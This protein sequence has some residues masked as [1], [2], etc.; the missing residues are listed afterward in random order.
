MPLIMREVDIL[1]K[2]DNSHIVKFIESF[3]IQNCLYFILEYVE[4][5]SLHKILNKFGAL[6]ENLVGI[7]TRQALE[8]L[9]YLHSTNV[10]HRDIK[11]DNML[12]TKDG[13][14]KL[15]DF[16]SVSVTTNEGKTNMTNSVGGTPYWMAPE[17]IQMEGTFPES[18]IW[19]IGCCVIELLKGTP[20]YFDLGPMAALFAMVD[21]SHPQYPYDITELTK[22]FLDRCFKRD[23]KKRPS[24][25]QLLSHPWMVASLKEKPLALSE[26]NK[27]MREIS[28]KRSNNSAQEAVDKEQLKVTIDMLKKQLDVA[29]NDNILL[30]KQ[31]AQYLTSNGVPSKTQNKLQDQQ[32]SQSQP[33][34]NSIQQSAQQ[35]FQSKPTQNSIQQSAQTIENQP[36][37]HQSSPSAPVQ[38]FKLSNSNQVN[39]YLEDSYSQVNPN[40]LSLPNSMSALPVR[41]PE[42]TSPILQTQPISRPQILS[43]PNIPTALSTQNLPPGW[44]I[45][46]DQKG[47]PYFIDHNKRTTTYQDPRVQ[48]SPLPQ[49]TPQ[50]SFQPNP[51]H[52]RSSIETQNF[53][54]IPR[55]SSNALPNQSKSNPNSM[56]H[57]QPSYTSPYGSSSAYPMYEQPKLNT[58]PTNFDTRSPSNIAFGILRGR[59]APPC[60]CNGYQTGGKE[61]T[62]RLCGHFPAW[63]DMLGETKQKQS[64]S[65]K[66]EKKK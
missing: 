53:Y 43:Q 46:L 61:M 26:V 13:I 40:S 60:S 25:E 48:P 39:P 24:A 12:L 57:F 49:R 36:K 65:D 35:P 11:S 38:T 27:T 4:G 29:N 63:H 55:N 30:R 45:S 56:N 59:C 20:P 64:K 44:E 31:L 5:G 22:D 37:P 2:L 10:L 9:K 7:Y 42:K 23:P 33:T 6:P 14:V 62:C 21:N 16:G 66:K 3:D 50:Q 34:Q 41:Q 1:K 8:G 54:E 51:G 32:P 17:V 18:D 52:S 28:K 19:S 58:P 47:R 15:A